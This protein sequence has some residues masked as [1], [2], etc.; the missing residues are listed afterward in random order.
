MKY[1]WNLTQN[2]YSPANV[3]FT[4]EKLISEVPGIAIKKAHFARQT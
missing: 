2:L 3:I 4:L 1:A